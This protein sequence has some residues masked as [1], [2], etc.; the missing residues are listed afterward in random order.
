MEFKDEF[1]KLFKKSLRT[2]PSVGLPTLLA[3]RP[4]SLRGSIRTEVSQCWVF[5]PM[6]S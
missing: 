1:V 2:L 4:E 3:Y 6:W 5:Q